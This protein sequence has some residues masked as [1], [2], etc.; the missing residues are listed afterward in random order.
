MF[1]LAV[2]GMKDIKADAVYESAAASL[3]GQPLLAKSAKD[4]QGARAWPATAASSSGTSWPP[5]SAG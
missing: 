1:Q 2:R 4:E 5:P 3:S